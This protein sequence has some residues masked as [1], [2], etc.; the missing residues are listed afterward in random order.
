MSSLQSICPC[1]RSTRRPPLQRLAVVYALLSSEECSANRHSAAAAQLNEPSISH[2][3]ITTYH[4]GLNGTRETSQWF[5]DRV[6]SVRGV[7]GHVDIPGE[8]LIGLTSNNELV[9]FAATMPIM[10]SVAL[11]RTAFGVG[12]NPVADRLRIHS[13]TNQNLRTNVET[14]LT[15]LDG[16]LAYTA[17]DVNAGADPDLTATGYT[18]ND[19]DPATGTELYAIDVAQDVLVEF[20][21]A[22]GTT[23]GP[24]SGKLVT[25][26]APGVDAGLLS[27]FD[28]SNT[29]G[30]AYA[31]LS[32]SASGKS[33][34]Y[35]INLDTG[36]ATKVGLLAQSKGPLL[37]VVVKP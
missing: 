26:G 19:A 30:I 34:L 20:G 25:V 21:P 32:T 31:V 24:N 10:L 29:T 22:V 7:S 13:N 1:I 3:H 28:I 17:G 6:A 35:T 8:Q 27:G 36:T 11:D 5:S 12:F 4:A 37:S 33:V 9:T 18:N 14:G 16:A 15:I 23:S 2:S